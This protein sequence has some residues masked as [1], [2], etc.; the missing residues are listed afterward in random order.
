[1]GTYL[2]RKAFEGLP[3]ALRRQRLHRSSG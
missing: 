1:L 2:D 3:K